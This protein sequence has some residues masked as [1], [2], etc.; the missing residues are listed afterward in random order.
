MTYAIGSP[1]TNPANS[2]FSLMLQTPIR[3]LTL[4]RN[5][6]ILVK[7]EIVAHSMQ[8]GIRSTTKLLVIEVDAQKT[9]MQKGGR[10]VGETRETLSKRG[11]SF[12]DSTFGKTDSLEA[13]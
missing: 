5:N 13:W 3:T 9:D 1:G 12:F 11:L 2:H 4:C 8:K 6:R 10:D 7:L